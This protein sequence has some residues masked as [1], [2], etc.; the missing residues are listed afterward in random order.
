MNPATL[1][2]CGDV[3]TG[4][5]IDQILPRPG[6]PAIREPYMDS[7]LGYVQLAEEANGPIPRPV[8]A[9]YIWGDAL[10]EFQ[11]V[12]PQ[13]RIINLETP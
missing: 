6:D 8:D 5:G 2:L 9:S 3:M 11:R 13:A 1:F 10:A 12:K 7:A 4:R